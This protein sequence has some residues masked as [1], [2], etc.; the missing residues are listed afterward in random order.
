MTA[1]SLNSAA[2]RVGS[3]PLRRVLLANPRGFCA[4]VE[5]AIDAVEQTLQ[6]HGAPVYVRRAIVHN[7]AVVEK[8]ERA[9]AIFVQEID[10]IPEGAIA[11]LSAHGSARLVRQAAQSR[12][13]RVVDAICPLVAKVHAEVESWYRAGRHI[14]LIGHIG[15]P[16]IVGT[17]GQV[18]AGAASVVCQPHDLDA[19]DLA[20]N[21]A[22]AYAVQT[23]FSV[24]DA[25]DMIAAIEQRFADVTG[26]RSSDICYATTN[27]QAA[28]EAIAPKCDLVLVVGDEMSSNARRLV[29]VALAAGAPA[30]RLIAGAEGLPQDSVRA[31]S[32][33]GLTAAASTPEELVSG[34]CD[35]LAALGCEVIESAGEIER[36]RFKPVALDPLNPAG[37]AGSLEDRLSRLR[38]DVEIELDQAIGQVRGRDRRLAEAMRYATLG[39]GKRF[40]ALL[41]AAVSELVGGAYAQALR[42]GAAIECVHAQSLVH[43]DLPCMDDDD[44]RR[45]RP[46]LHR[47][48]DEATAVLAGDA[49]LALAFEILA[50]EATHPDATTRA[51]L[52]LSLARA[53]GQDGLAGGQMMDLFPPANP[54]PQDV[55]ECESRKTGALIRFAVEAGAM[56]GSCSAEERAR[57]LQFAENLGLVFQI[58]DDMLDTIGE[59]EVVG[60]AVGKDADAGRRSATALL[61]LDGAA[62]HAS[63]L[64]QAC[65]E[66][67]EAF[68]AKATPLRDLT[69]FAVSRMH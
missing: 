13:L 25:A 41:V 1:R 45:G 56:L 9:G 60:K 44:L 18:P 4:G 63:L 58:R 49:L 46:T 22:I 37:L 11:I 39:G 53:V 3:P 21:T 12:H 62:H 59:A 15:H 29:D 30:A 67:L 38:Q 50:D 34:V 48:F 19:L 26:P 7:R 55:F 17:L 16:E 64:E 6:R 65:N 23:T 51:S 27:R 52:V 10:D 32:T 42:V 33:I 40:R 2:G 5:R 14:L 68:G 54:T 31:S 36:V 20:P 66:A 24:R 35:A 61:G 57:L 43:D 69:R 28:I 47:K 8:L